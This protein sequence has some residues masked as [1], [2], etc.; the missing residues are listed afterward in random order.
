MED[1]ETGGGPL[2]LVFPLVE[3]K[4]KAT[5]L[6]HCLLRVVDLWMLFLLLYPL[7]GIF[8]VLWPS[9]LF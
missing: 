7:V 5:V 4:I 3:D 9:W 6:L 1:D 8:G 2:S